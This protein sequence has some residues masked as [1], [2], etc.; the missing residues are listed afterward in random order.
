VTLLNP[1]GLLLLLAVPAIVLL[2]LFLQERRRRE[3]SSLFLWRQVTEQHSRRMRPRLLRN[4]HLLLQILAAVLAALALAQPVLPGAARAGSARLI[5]LIDTSASMSAREDQITRLELAKNRARELIGR[6]RR[7]TQVM[8]ATAGARPSVVQSFTSD[9]N[10]LYEVI[11]TIEAED[12]TGNLE[13]A[14]LML[15]S[16]QTNGVTEVHL[17]TDGAFD[18]DPNVVLPRNFSVEQVGTPVPN[19]AIT[20]F[21]ARERFDGSALEAYLEIANFDESEVELTLQLE[22]DARDAS[23]L[24]LS[25]GPNEIRPVAVT[26]PRRSGTVFTARLAGNTDAL[27]T[28][29]TASVVARTVRPL[30]VQLVTQGNYFLESILSVY[31]NAVLTV[32]PTV[33]RTLPY[34]LLILDGVDAPTGTTGNILAFDAAVPGAPFA[35]QEKVPVTGPI[36][37][38]TTHPVAASVDLSNVNITDARRYMLSFPNAGVQDYNAIIYIFCE[39]HCV[40]IKWHFV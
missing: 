19:R 16:V 21:E 18:L 27:A 31:P 39:F 28:D 33:D 24:A 22:T 13:R 8:V 29:D 9:R 23:E 11:R 34:D 7:D 25:L 12:G 6:S 3:V 32:T 15:R 38:S 1:L 26:L 2:H 17:I 20:A 4:I 30:R 40:V 36:T 10:A 35:A 5:V 37:V 14:A